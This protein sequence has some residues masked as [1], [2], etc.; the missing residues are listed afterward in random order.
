[1]ETEEDAFRNWPNQR[2]GARLLT[3]VA[4]GT[5]VVAVLGWGLLLHKISETSAFALRHSERVHEQL[6]AWAFAL[7]AL[8]L[9]AGV[10]AIMAVAATVRLRKAKDALVARLRRRLVDPGIP[11][12][13]ARRIGPRSPIPI[14]MEG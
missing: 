3:G 11:A 5:G 8:T 10:V 4:I 13:R 1:M 9:I 12:A 14:T 7:G 2:A 6:G